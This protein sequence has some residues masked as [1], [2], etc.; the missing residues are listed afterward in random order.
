MIL[1]RILAAILFLAS[2]GVPVSGHA[3]VQPPYEINVILPLSGYGAFL[4]RGQAETLAVVEKYVNETGG[5]R[6]RPLHFVSVDSQSSPQVDIQLT[7]TI[8]A[9]HPSLVIEGGP[10]TVCHAVATFYEKGPVMWCLSPAFFPARGGYAF[11]SGVES[12]VGMEVTLRYLRT[13]GFKRLGIIT[14]TDIAGQEADAALKRLLA[15]P[16]NAGLRVVAWEHLGSSDVGVDAQ[17]AKIKQGDP[18]V[19]IGWATGAPT[20]TMLRGFK[21]TGMSVPFVVSN[22][23]QTPVQMQQYK[24]IL[25]HE[26]L[27]YSL[28]WPSY[29]SLRPGPLKSAM[30]PYFRYMSAAGLTPDGG[31]PL[32][33][34]SALL[35]VRALRTLGTDAGATQIRDYLLNL[36]DYYGP[37]GAFDFRLGNQRGL[38]SNDLVMVR[39]NAVASSWQVVSEP[40]GKAIK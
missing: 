2:W 5:I 39:W 36:H 9:K 12:A 29:Q 37:S 10:A 1:A 35:L 27:M 8:L 15:D 4:G 3:Q 18:E 19:V 13:R 24:E 33:W 34:D 14:L 23:N 11:S 17:M 30:T 16:A 31:A 20:G 22:A 21:N 38:A 25:P 26:Y 40:A 6:G 32:A 7:Q 28:R